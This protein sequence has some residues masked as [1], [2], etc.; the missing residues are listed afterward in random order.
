MWLPRGMYGD[1]GA[2]RGMWS[3]SNE[4]PTPRSPDYT[5]IQCRHDQLKQDRGKAPAAA[6]REH[7]TA[8]KC[9]EPNQHMGSVLRSHIQ[10][11]RSTRDRNVCTQCQQWRLC[12]RNC[13]Q[14]MR[15]S[16]AAR[17]C[18]RGGPIREHRYAGNE[19]PC[20][21]GP[22]WVSVARIG[23]RRVGEMEKPS[24][25]HACLRVYDV[26]ISRSSAPPAPSPKVASLVGVLLFLLEHCSL[27]R[28]ILYLALIG[29]RIHLEVF[30]ASS[31]LADSSAGVSM[32]S[33]CSTE[34]HSQSPPAG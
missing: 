23:C 29:L 10:R 24:L 22:A 19:W 16:R 13:L 17:A 18:W 14:P 25:T 26:T 4:H 5:W 1:N 11:L 28:Q 9:G 20:S 15:R 30:D 31:Q 8:R 27:I 7:A 3:K 12:E 34:Q 33:K 2:F 32:R 6:C 21:S